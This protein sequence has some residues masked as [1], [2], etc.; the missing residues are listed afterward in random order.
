MKKLLIF[1]SFLSFTGC[2][3]ESGTVTRSSVK[4]HTPMTFM[5]NTRDGLYQCEV[6][7]GNEHCILVIQ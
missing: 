3:H 4:I 6:Y 1:L 5:R 7:F 2:V